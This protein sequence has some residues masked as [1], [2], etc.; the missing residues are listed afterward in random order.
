[1]SRSLKFVTG[2]A[3]IM[4]TSAASA[5]QINLRCHRPSE[6]PSD[7]DISIELDTTTQNVISYG[8][9]DE[10]QTLYWSEEV[11]YWYARGSWGN[12]SNFSLSAYHPQSSQLIGH[13]INH[14]QFDQSDQINILMQSLP[15]G[16]PYT[17]FR[18]GK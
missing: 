3:L 14:E 12:H 6:A 5:E 8:R 11:I 7:N 18:A 15:V 17:C 16:P 2:L 1:M 10:V 13:A 9:W 4:S